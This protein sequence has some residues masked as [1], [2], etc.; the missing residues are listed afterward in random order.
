MTTGSISFY[1]IRFKWTYFGF[2]LYRWVT[3]K[4]VWIDLT[5]KNWGE[6]EI[7]LEFRWVQIWIGATSFDERHRRVGLNV[8]SNMSCRADSPFPGEELSERGI[9]YLLAHPL[10]QSQPSFLWCS[11][12][13]EK[14]VCV[15]VIVV[16]GFVTGVV[17]VVHPSTNDHD[18]VTMREMIRQR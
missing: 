15:I 16:T 12:I 11:I 18:D 13:F 10:S 14:R 7:I 5:W 9:Q 6:M 4:T 17:V 2:V 1:R 3:Y 8:S